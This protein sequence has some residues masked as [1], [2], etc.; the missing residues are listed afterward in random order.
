VVKNVAG[1]DLPKLGHRGFG[2][3]GVITR[4]CFAC[5]RFPGTCARFSISAASAEEA[6]RFVLAIQDSKL[7]H[8][9]LQSHFS[10]AAPPVSDILFEG[11]DAGLAAQEAQLRHLSA[12]ASVR[13]AS[14]PTWT[15][16]EELWTFSEPAST[17]MA[18]INILPA[19]MARTMS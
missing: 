8:S 9:F 18:K 7:A 11:T 12:P 3:L 4:A 19:D 14:K 15:A 6:Q 16:R 17:A 13:E 1:Y 10:D 2:T 5:I